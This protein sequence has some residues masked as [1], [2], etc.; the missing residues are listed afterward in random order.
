M[1]K[2]Y[3]VMLVVLII[4]MVVAGCAQPAPAPAP[5]PSPA[6]SPTPAPAPSFPKLTFVTPPSGTQPNTVAVAWSTLAGK[7]V[8]GL[9][10][11][12]EPAIGAPHAVAGFLQGNGDIVYDSANIFG[13]EFPKQHGG[14]PL[15]V[16]PMHLVA[17]QG[18]CVHIVARTETGIKSVADFKGRKILGKVATGGGVDLTR[19]EILAAYGMGAGS[20]RPDLLLVDTEKHRVSLAHHGEL[21]VTCH[22]LSTQK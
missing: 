9:Q 22:E 1:K 6:P 3:V 8:P 13:T 7:Y 18:G 17:S 10:I 11:L 15:S 4:G 16:G 5:S 12:I 14:E 20:D 2:I 21:H 19:K